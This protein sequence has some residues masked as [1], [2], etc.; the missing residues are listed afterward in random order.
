MIS[1]WYVLAMMFKVL[2]AFV[3][4]FIVIPWKIVRF[5]SEA[6]KFLDK[7]FICLIHSTLIIILVAHILAFSKLYEYFSLVFVLFLIIIISKYWS[8]KTWPALA[9]ALGV[10]AIVHILDLS[11]GRLGLKEQLRQKWTS[12]CALRKARVSLFFRSYCRDPFAFYLP[13]AVILA[14]AY[15]RFEHSIFNGTFTLSDTYGH[16]AWSKRMGLNEIYYYGV[17]SYGLHSIISAIS[18]LFFL[19][20]YWICRFLGPLAGAFLVLSVYYFALRTTENKAASLL[21]AV[22]YGLVTHSDFPSAAYR[23]TALL[24]QEY[25]T[26]FVLPGLYFFWVYLKSRKLNY[27]LLFAAALSVTAFIHPFA[28]FFLAFWS[29]IMF[30]AAWI[31]LKVNYRTIFAYGLYSFGAILIALVPLGIGLLMGMDFYGSSADFIKESV[32]TNWSG[33]SLNQFVDIMLSGGVLQDGALIAACGLIIISFLLFRLKRNI[34]A[35]LVLTVSVGAILTFLQYRADKL[36]LP[37]LIAPFRTGT[38]LA[39]LIPVVY[40]WGIF[41]IIIMISSI[42]ATNLRRLKEITT[43]TLTVTLCLIVIYMHPPGD[44]YKELL[45]YE[46]AVQNYLVIKRD[47]PAL[48][49]TIVG[50]TE[51]LEQVIGVG[52]H[53][54]IL[55]LVQRYTPEEVG[56]PGFKWPIPT[57]HIFFYTE[58]IPFH[59]GRPVALSDAEKELEPEGND[60][61]SQYYHTGDQRAIL[62]AKAIRLM[63]AYRANHDMSIFYEDEEMRI[64]YVYQKL[65]PN[66]PINLLDS[67]LAQKSAVIR[68]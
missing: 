40:S 6:D 37:V 54:D 49:W 18:K 38:F 41:L 28:T 11:E 43:K 31:P 27:L 16:L 58:K 26:I 39:L 3:V 33:I 64:Y 10:R 63:E 21:S 2:L 34:N 5:D 22:V 55:R 67:E 52:W 23:Q 44:L 62:E 30:L 51:Q 68:Q 66:I 19:D 32:S 60:P 45:E 56:K 35:I 50:P 48:D 13:L 29:G 57:S 42:S 36:S 65:D 7:V 53:S 46:A 14:A 9:E 8:V 20:A 17:Y 1:Q 15:L 4:V 59:W 25:A 61:F 47:F 12:W 24:T